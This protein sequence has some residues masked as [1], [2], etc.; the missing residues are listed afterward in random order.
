MCA[1]IDY[2]QYY[3]CYIYTDQCLDTS[4]PDPWKKL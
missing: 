2:R 1:C 3:T 4:V